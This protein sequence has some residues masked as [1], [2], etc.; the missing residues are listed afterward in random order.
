MSYRDDAGQLARALTEL[1][2]THPVPPAPLT[3]PQVQAALVCRDTLVGA[4]RD[5]TGALLRRTPLPLRTDRDLLTRSPV[6]ALHAA[7]TGL[8]PASDRQLALTEALA[9]QAGPP[10]D[11]WQRAARAA[12]LLEAYRDDA[13]A[14]PGPAAWSLARDLAAVSS[15]LPPLD[16]DLA[17]TLTATVAATPATTSEASALVGTIGSLLDGPSHGLLQLSASE[18]AAHTADVPLAAAALPG[19]SRQPI[20]PV[21]HLADLPVA[22][23]Q[24]ADLLHRR[25]GRLTVTEARAALRTV[26]YGLHLTASTLTA[27]TRGTRPDP[28]TRSGL[29]EA[30]GQLRAALPDLQVVMQSQLATLTSPAPA[31]LLLSQQIHT[32]LSAAGRLHDAL[33]PG[34]D[35]GPAEAGPA[36]AGAARDTL[37]QAL[38]RW[39]V[40]A[41]P[42]VEAVRGGLRAASDS[43]A[44]L[45]PRRDDAPSRYGSW[46]YLPLRDTVTDPALQAADQ[47]ARTVRRATT[48]LTALLGPPAASG[49]GGTRRAASDAAAA[50]S[51]LTV[52][53]QSRP[54]RAWLNPT[55]SAH[56][57]LPR[58]TSRK[59][60]ATPADPARPGRPRG[61]R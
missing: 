31:L 51:E 22:S 32:Q 12:A 11:G 1:L 38:T 10:V 35:T 15:A 40:T 5:L 6:H 37:H 52:A 44:L 48:S 34:P 3:P 9:V 29:E 27:G 21:A 41:A 4:V 28:N 17:A 57:A 14:L 50:F 13:A 47:A 45:A 61:A 54:P 24:L 36:G 56:P 20:R 43:G 18:L 26:A 46:L 60:P 55:R 16:L 33:Q 23:A 59:T 7:L 30:A 49:T 58:A 2:T 53:L 19:R 42:V 8:P 25:G 39:A